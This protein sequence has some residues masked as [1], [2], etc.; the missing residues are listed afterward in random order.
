MK[1]PCRVLHVITTNLGGAG[2]H[3]LTLVKG[4]VAHGWAVEVAVS[5]GGPLDQEFAASGATM[6]WIEM[7]RKVSPM[8]DLGAL[9][10]LRRLIRRGGFDLIATHTSK[11]GLLGRVGAVFSGVP[12]VHMV[13]A[14]ASDDHLPPAKRELYRWIE[15]GLDSL[16][17]H[18]IAGSEAIRQMGLQRRIMRAEKISTIHYTL[19]L[20]RFQ[21]VPDKDQAR[22]LLGLPLDKPMVGWAGR[23][24]Q[25]KA[26]EA[27]A[28]M[29]AL[30]A[31][32][33]PDAHFLMVGDGPL[34]PGTE[35]LVREYGL[36]EHF[37]FL[38][39]RKEIPAFMSAMDVFALLSAWEAFGLVFAE[40]QVCRTPAV[41][42]AVQGIPEVV[43][44]GMTGLLVPPG[45][46]AA[47]AR[48]VIRLLQDE[49]LRTRM[50]EAA[51]QWVLSRFDSGAMTGSTVDL[52]ER[53]LA[54]K[55]P[56]PA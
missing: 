29:A 2:Q 16:T 56:G 14:Y 55:R 38:G 31:H 49:A 22:Q 40:A 23:F 52:Y 9:C 25:Q 42:T 28:H 7:D 1:K 32:E 34:R 35:A 48:A 4:L 33:V 41:G 30:I 12:A 54:A 43:Q 37:H 17:T 10:Q 11:A 47:G 19:E 21:T 3:V 51:R 24:E 45:D 44:D 53:L 50:G 27:F 46:V 39:W 13:H 15:C 6:H 18:Y 36:S 20:E 8:R 26:P 5:P